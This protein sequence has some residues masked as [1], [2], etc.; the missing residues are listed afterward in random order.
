MAEILGVVSGCAGLASLVLQLGE[1]AAQLKK[2]YND[3]QG[4]PETLRDTAY[5]MKTMQMI[6]QSIQDDQ[7]LGGTCG[8]GIL[9]RC[10]YMCRRR[11][12]DISVIAAKLE[13]TMQQSK[14]RGKLRTA[15][16]DKEIEQLCVKLDRATAQLGLA[17]QLYSE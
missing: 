12:E 9:D 4:A 3:Y 13:K 10:I 14:W 1:N 5:T 6:L 7:E 11:I 16:E 17:Y 15:S 2:L 8:F